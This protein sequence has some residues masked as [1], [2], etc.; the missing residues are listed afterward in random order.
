MS[1][2]FSAELLQRRYM[3]EPGDAT[4]YEFSMTPC[5][6]HGNMISGIGNDGGYVTLVLHSPGFGGYEVHEDFLRNPAKHQAMYLQPHFK[7]G[8]YTIMAI[9]LAC[10]VLIND[11]DDLTGAC[12][13]MLKV[14]EFLA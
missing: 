9:L 10:S 13:K 8:L 12:E 7:V 1:R 14:H 5:A 3:L 11:P 6:D 2:G 4:R